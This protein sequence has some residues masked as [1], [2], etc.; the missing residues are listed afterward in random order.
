MSINRIA[1]NKVSLKRFRAIGSGTGGAAPGPAPATSYSV[2]Q[3][4]TGSQTWTPPSGVTTVDYVVAAGGGGGGQGSNA[5]GAN[6]GGGG[7]GG[8]QIGTGITVTPGTT[9]T[10]T[11]GAGGSGSADTN[12]PVVNGSNSTFNA[13]TSTGGGGG[14]H[15]Q[16][17]GA[18]G[19]GGTI[20][21]SGNNRANAGSPGGNSTF[22][23]PATVAPGTLT[24]IG[25][26]GG[27]AANFLRSCLGG[28]SGATHQGVNGNGGSGSG[29]SGSG[30]SGIVI[31][32]YANTLPAASATGSPNVT[33]SG[34]YRVYKFISSGTITLTL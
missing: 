11:V 20:N 26:L 5:P 32:R 33:V 6:G 12:G 13:I 27:G 29:G 34:G 7:A 14:G 18:G 22:L 25:G 1:L 16:N 8:Y 3:A 23:G 30:G 19:N 28:C 21:S 4:F 9:Y 24:A 2:I 15:Y 31:I 17:P 10:V